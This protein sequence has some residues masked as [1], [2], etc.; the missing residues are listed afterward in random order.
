MATKKST[1]KKTKK[2]SDT[3][4]KKTAKKAVSKAKTAKKVVK[5]APKFQKIDKPLTRSQQ[6]A[7]I[8]E[9]TGV[10][11]KDVHSV[12]DSLEPMI[13]AHLKGAGEISVA[14]LMKI[15]VIRKPAT[16]AR[17]GVNPFNGEP[18]IFKAKP[19]RNVIKIRPLK[20]LKDKV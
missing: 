1:A 10:S 4:T 8:A 6:I 20:K 5:S 13:A 15:K 18:T 12:V 17:K 19:A 14:G 11:K 9:T 7:A 3:T 2:A 16:K